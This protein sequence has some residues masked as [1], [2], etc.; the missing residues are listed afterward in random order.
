MGGNGGNPIGGPGIAPG[1]KPAG[2][3]AKP[4]GGG[5]TTAKPGGG[6]GTS[7]LTDS[8]EC[9]IGRGGAHGEMLVD[10]GGGGGSV[11][12]GGGGPSH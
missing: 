6:G 1:G 5:R 4:K 3:G 9:S 10:M 8:T 11:C 7:A 12:S 2:I